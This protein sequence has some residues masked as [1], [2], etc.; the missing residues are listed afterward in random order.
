VVVTGADPD[1]RLRALR[2]TLKLP[3]LISSPVFVRGEI[4]AFLITGR[5]VEATPFLSRL[6][7]SDAETVQAIGALLASVLLQQRLARAEERGRILLDAMPMCCIFWDENGNQTDCNKEALRL[8]GLSSKR[9]FLERFYSLSPEFQPDGRLSERTAREN[10]LRAFIAGHACFEWTY[11]TVSGELI[12]SEVT[13]VRVPRG[14]GYN[15]AGY[16]RDLREQKA[17]LADLSEARDAAERNARVKSE[18]LANISHEIRTPLN[19]ILGMT[20]VMA[21]VEMDEKRR[22]FLENGAHSAQLLASVID[23]LLDFS[24]I[25]AGRVTLENREFSPRG[26]VDSV[27]DMLQEE[28]RGK[29]ITLRSDIDPEVPAVLTG[30]PV[31]LEQVLFNL[32]SNSVKFT[33]S[34]EVCL[35]V[36][37]DILQPGKARVAFAV[38][39]TG[40]GIAE[41]KIDKLFTPLT[42]GDSSYGR[43]H[44][45]IGM[46]LAV[47]RGL[48]ALM[49]GEITCVSRLGEGSTFTFSVT[50]GLSERAVREEAGPAEEKYAN[51]RGMR[52]LLAEDN[53]I[54][55]MI[56]VEILSEA[57]VETTTANTGLAALNAL[58]DGVF[59]VI[60]MDIQMPEMDGLPAAARIRADGRALPILAMTAH[61]SP[62]DR[63]E[64]L[65]AGMNDHLTKPIEPDQLYEALTRWGKSG[66]ENR[67]LEMSESIVV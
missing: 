12:P 60:L 15:M 41:E 1:S 43:K 32:A 49:G 53:L 65:K 2:E 51:L 37:C 48:A 46:G 66:S 59:D 26:L 29:A 54:N 13:L 52:V 6:G 24:R 67:S 4:T 28:A 5:L 27:C 30:D 10:V 18:F 50:L 34:G 31:R 61:A 39:D 23:S 36:A 40:I 16:I 44:S 7:R 45:G 3:Y 38:R 55:Q 11:R 64:C 25:D 63:E 42:Q 62:E 57:G 21:E 20:R 17:M 8:F 35:H 58:E 56:A 22:K 33:E 47:S 9:E 19:A 14:D